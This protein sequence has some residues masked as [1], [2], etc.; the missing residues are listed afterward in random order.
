M[1]TIRATVE[2]WLRAHQKDASAR[3]LLAD[4]G[5]EGDRQR[6]QLDVVSELVGVEVPHW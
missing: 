5:A 4:L 1:M 3:E 6:A 2:R